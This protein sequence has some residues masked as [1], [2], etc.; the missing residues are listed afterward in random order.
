MNF[1]TIAIATLLAIMSTAAT[2]NDCAADIAKVNTGMTSTVP[3]DRLKKAADLRDRAT[4]LCA[5][6]D[7]S[8]G[9][10]LLAEAKAILQIQ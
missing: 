7:A 6:G 10:A 9:L 5:T 4:V 3:P 1:S 2:A 8:G